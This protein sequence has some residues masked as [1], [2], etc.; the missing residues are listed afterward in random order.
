MRMGGGRCE[1]AGLKALRFQFLEF[2]LRRAVGRRP[3]QARKG[4]AVQPE[5]TNIVFALKLSSI[6]LLRGESEC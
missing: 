4:L 2:A 1:R 6:S 3:L 5:A